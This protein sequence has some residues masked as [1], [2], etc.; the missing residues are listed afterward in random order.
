MFK[1]NRYSIA[2]A[3]AVL[4]LLP[5]V[6]LCAYTMDFIAG[7]MSWKFFS[8]GL[9]ITS[10]GSTILFILM[11][12]LETSAEPIAEQL[13]SDKLSEVI[14]SNDQSM[15]ESLTEWKQKHG[16]SVKE[17]LSYKEGLQQ[18]VKEKEN[19]QQEWQ[20]AS[21]ELATY[22]NAAEEQLQ[23]KERILQECQQTA[24]EQR[25]LIEKHQQHIALL[26]SKERDLHY[27]LQTLLQLTSLDNSLLDPKSS[28]SLNKF[29]GHPS[30]YAVNNQVNS[31][32]TFYT[33]EAAKLQLKRCIDIATKM[34]GANYF[35][36]NSARSNEFPVDSYNLD[37]RRL[38]DSLRDEHN[39][40]LIVYSL[41]ENR[42]L[43][44]N[45]QVKNILGW[46]SEKFVQNSSEIIQEEHETW[47]T[48]IRQLS[49]QPDLQ[50]EVA[51]KSKM[52]EAVSLQC[53]LGAIHT[54]LFRNHAIGL[55]Y[56]KI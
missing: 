17:A 14:P 15:Q 28:N 33:P 29:E 53:Y 35:G 34:T 50:M 12:R 49:I 46:T 30:A 27:E 8:I 40:M 52:G 36:P 26:E 47:R 1:P 2:G 18:A 25:T 56:P 41:K 23:Y 20:Q 44:V 11:C 5:I 55:L 32:A 3:I 42:V 39:Y 7:S 21:K 19:Y 48:G 43:F 51:M 22:K 31:P 54:G 16:E 37:L 24:R 9:I 38:F 4:Y 45:N 10:I 6:I 13:N